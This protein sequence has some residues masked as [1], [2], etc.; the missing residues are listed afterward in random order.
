MLP[1]HLILLE[2]VLLVRL[3]FHIICE[4]KIFGKTMGGVIPRKG[5]PLCVTAAILC[6]ERLG[7][8]PPSGS[9]LCFGSRELTGEPTASAVFLLGF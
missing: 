4:E 8:L 9:G 7:L 1:A 5:F 2:T 6:P 3:C